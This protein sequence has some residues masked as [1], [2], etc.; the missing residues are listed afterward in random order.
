MSGLIRPEEAS[1]VAHEVDSLFLFLVVLSACMCAL[2][3]STLAY[4]AVKYR[5][6]SEDEIPDPVTGGN[7]LEI[8]WTLTPLVVFMGIFGWGASIY[9]TMQ[10]PPPDCLEVYCVGKQWMWKFQHHDGQRE[11]DELHVPLGRPVKLIMSSEDVIHSFFVPA[12]RVKQDVIPG[13]YTTLWFEATKPGSFDIFCAQYCGTKH[14]AMIG[15]VVVLEPARYQNWLGG[16]VEG[17]LAGAGQRLFQALGCQ[18]CHTGGSGARGPALEGLF[19]KE[20]L[21]TDG[22]RVIADEGY[23]R[24]SILS[25]AAKVVAGYQP[26]MPT[27]AGQVTEEQIVQL[28][29][30]LKTLQ[31]GPSTPPAEAPK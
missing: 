21:L 30:Y 31:A 15:K 25:P 10:R 20:V 17:S 26:I 18:T 24:E 16:G 23:Y 2:I 13:R 3:F 7:W 11:I 4:F 9:F 8:G 22:R 27:Y 28:I 1:T 14:S 5:R 12:F 19:G 6:R 29:A